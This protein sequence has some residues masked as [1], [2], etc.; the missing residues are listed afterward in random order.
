MTTIP[1]DLSLHIRD[2]VQMLY[3]EDLTDV[4]L[5]G[6]SYGGAVVDGV[7]DV[8]T[9]RLRHVVN[10]DGEVVQEGRTLMDGWTDEARTEMSDMLEQA[11]ATAWSPAPSADDLADVLD[12]PQLR[13]WGGERTSS[14]IR[15]RHRA[16]SGQRR[17]SVLGAAH[18]SPVHRR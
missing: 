18:L 6:W 13:A 8:V 15:N 7:A 12:D 14:T 16:I 1:I 10:L 17:P 4:V 9:E 11:H 3:F 2:V 5:V